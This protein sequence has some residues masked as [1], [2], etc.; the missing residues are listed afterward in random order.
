MGVQMSG[1]GLH[2]LSMYDAVSEAVEPNVDE[3]VTVYAEFVLVGTFAQREKTADA[4]SATVWVV[5]VIPEL[6]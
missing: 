6:K 2:S 4:S 3:T 1:A 5:V